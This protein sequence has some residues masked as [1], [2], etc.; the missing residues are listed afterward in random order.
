MDFQIGKH[1]KNEKYTRNFI[2]KLEGKKIF[3]RLWRI[4]EDYI[5]EG[6]K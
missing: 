4:L 1:W 5:K 3:A 6:L 2:R